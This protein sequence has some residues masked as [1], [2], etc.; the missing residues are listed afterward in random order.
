[1]TTAAWRV[2]EREARIYRRLW[3]GNFFSSFV[4][5]SL[6]LGAMGLGLGGLIDARGRTAEGLTYLQFVAPGLMAAT[7]L[8]L[9]AADSLWPVMGGMKWMRHYHA[10]VAA[11][12]RPGDV[13]VG[14]LLW[15]AARLTISSTAFLLVAAAL[16]GVASPG[17]VLAVPAAVLGGVAMGAPLMAFAAT[18]DHE[19]RFGLVMRFV[20]LPLFL[21]SGT[22]FPISQLPGPLQPLVWL[23]P[24]WHSVELC[25]AA[26]TGHWA[27]PG[28]TLAHLVLL[29]ALLM[30]SG[31]AGIRSF[32][33]RLA[34]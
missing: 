10:M 22:F 14:N 20:V 4:S 15:L 6:Y 13:Y 24:L 8:Q 31:L 12:L 16:G 28:P 23:S 33:A 3:R 18:Q 34:S 9:A 30:A 27:A 26:T 32:T 5:P 29:V 17:A 25:R 7:A 1:M 2:V 19:S 11:P 21:F